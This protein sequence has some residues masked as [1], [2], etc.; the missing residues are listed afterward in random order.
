MKKVIQQEE[1]E[2]TCDKC[3]EIIAHGYLPV[4]V[5]FGYGTVFDG[6]RKHFCGLDCFVTW[7][8]GLKKEAEQ[9]EAENDRKG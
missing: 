2:Y 4:E 5:E 7:A 1:V 8:V 9:M 3:N 6:D